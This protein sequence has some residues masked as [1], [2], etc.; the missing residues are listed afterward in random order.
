M[1]VPVSLLGM[2]WMIYRVVVAART[3]GLIQQ[4]QNLASNH[5]ALLVSQPSNNAV[6]NPDAANNLSLPVLMALTICGKPGN[7]SH[8]NGEGLLKIS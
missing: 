1:H 3:G 5:F 8:A 2:D 4:Q 6:A 7:K